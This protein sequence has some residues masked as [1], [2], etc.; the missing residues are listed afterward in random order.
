MYKVVIVI[1][2]LKIYFDL[3]CDGRGYIRNGRMCGGVV[4]TKLSDPRIPPV[5][6]AVIVPLTL[7]FEKKIQS[8]PVL[9]FLKSFYDSPLQ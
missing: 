4:I 9:G 2:L 3:P 1:G 6:G 8:F 5:L 7:N